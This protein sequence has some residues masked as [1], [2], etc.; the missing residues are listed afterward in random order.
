MQCL[1]LTT[2]LAPVLS[3]AGPSVSSTFD[4]IRIEEVTVTAHHLDLAALGHA[5]QAAGQLADDLVLVAAQLVDVD[6]R[7]GKTDAE[8][9]GVLR[10]VDDLGDVQ[11][12]LGRDAP[13]IQ[14]DAAEGGIAFDDYGLEAEVGGTEGSRV[15]AGAGTED[16]QVALDVGTAIVAGGN[17][18]RC[19]CCGC[20]GRRRC[21]GRNRSSGAGFNLDQN[22]ALADL[23]AQL[24]QHFLDH[25]V[26]RG[27]HIHGRLVGLKGADGVVDL[28]AVA[29]LDEQ[30]DDRHVG[31]I[32]DVGD[33]DF[34]KLTHR[35]PPRRSCGACR[36]AVR[37]H[38][39]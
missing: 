2:F 34:N 3:W 1:N 32:A 33:F 22:G 14:A 13:D 35:I 10:L 39:R 26:D 16:E 27:R 5:G 17:R 24:D 21:G 19:R 8:I 36:P 18:C 6:L 12:G 9:S 38:R 20:C 30:V 4:V 37:R 15:T 23:A 28:D 31:E 7:R 25:A 29:D 11:Q